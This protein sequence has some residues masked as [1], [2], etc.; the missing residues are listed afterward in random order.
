MQYG[1]ANE[2]GAP[3]ALADPSFPP[4]PRQAVPSEWCI[5]NERSHETGPIAPKDEECAYD[6][7]DHID[8]HRAFERQEKPPASL[9]LRAQE[10]SGCEEAPK[11]RE[12]CER[13]KYRG[14]RQSCLGA[15]ERLGEQGV[16]ARPHAVERNRLFGVVD[17]QDKWHQSNHDAPRQ[18]PSLNTQ[19]VVT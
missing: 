13:L 15:R 1:P 2:R 3:G 6:V 17:G 18:R 16:E 11:Q 9:P 5:E 12:N 19:I 10:N 14:T 7:G 4:R 8:S